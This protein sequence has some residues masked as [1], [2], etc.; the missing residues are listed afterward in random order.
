METMLT[1]VIVI[2]LIIAFLALTIIIYDLM[3][4]QWSF[5]NLIKGFEGIA[6]IF[7]A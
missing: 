7:I 3:T 6:K 1:T 2:I 5:L 4:P